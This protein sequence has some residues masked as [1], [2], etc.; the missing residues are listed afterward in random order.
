MLCIV[1]PCENGRIGNVC[2]LPISGGEWCLGRERDPEAQ[3]NVYIVSGNAPGSKGRA[4]LTGDQKRKNK[5]KKAKREKKQK[6]QAEKVRLVQ[7]NEVEISV[8]EAEKIARELSGKKG[9]KGKRS[10]PSEGTSNGPSERGADPEETDPTDPKIPGLRWSLCALQ[11]EDRQR[12]ADVLNKHRDVFNSK[13]TPRLG[14]IK[15]FEFTIDTDDS[16]PVRSRPYRIKE[17]GLEEAMNKEIDR[18]LAEGII[19]P[20][21]SAD[22]ASPAL[23]VGKTDGTEIGRAHV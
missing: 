14:L 7:E 11:G 6:E 8:A 20:L 10:G 4:R 3:P 16:P 13:E 23:C 2:R 12:L 1:Q 18:M 19:V 15:G 9:K 21:L 5:K 17:P 22:W